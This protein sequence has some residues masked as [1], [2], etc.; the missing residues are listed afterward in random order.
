VTTTQPDI[1]GVIQGAFRDAWPLMRSRMT[2]YWVLALICGALVLVALALGRLADSSVQES[3]RIETAIQPANLC[4]VIAAFFAIPAIV[5][6]VQPEFKMTFI[7]ILAVIGIGLVVGVVAEL[8]LFLLIVPG[9]WFGVKLSL[10]TW[11]YLVSEDKNPFGEA[12]EITT[13]HFWETFGFLFV[14]S[15]LVTLVTIVVF[16]IP[17]CVAIFVPVSAVVLT[18]LAFLGYM[19]V[20]HVASLGEMRWMLELRRLA[21]GAVT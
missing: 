15:I 9:I 21:S 17:V 19:Y 5:R 16:F 18:P 4:G 6:T 7:R 20:Y 8:G 14:L 2:V 1:F 11:T 10:S 13:G 3:V 12:W